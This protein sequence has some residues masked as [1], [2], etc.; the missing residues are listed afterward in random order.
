MYWEGSG[1]IYKLKI[2]STRV[3]TCTTHHDSNNFLLQTENHYTV[4]R[5]PPEQ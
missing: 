4:C 5:V 3:T 2:K 1:K